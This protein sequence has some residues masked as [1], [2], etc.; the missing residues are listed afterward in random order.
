MNKSSEPR[1]SQPRRSAPSSS[2]ASAVSGLG[3][4]AAAW[5]ALVAVQT[6]ASERIGDVLNADA[7]LRDPGCDP[8]DATLA[9]ELALGAIRF[10]VL[11]DRLCD[12]F[13]RR[14]R[15][16][17]EVR[18]ALRLAAHQLFACDSVPPHAVGQ[19]TGALLRRAQCP[20]LVAVA[21]AVVRRLSELRLDERQGDGP[22]G[23]IDPRAHPEDEA[24]R[25]G[26]P[27]ALIRDLSSALDADGKRAERLAAMTKVPP[28]CTRHRPGARV[29]V[30][31]SVIKQEGDWWWWDDPQEAIHGHVADGRLVVQDRSQGRLLELVEPRPLDRVFDTCAAPGG[32]ALLFYDAGC[33]VVA[34]D[35]PGPRLDRMRTQMPAD[36]KIIAH[37][38]RDPSLDQQ[39]DIVLV[40]APCSNSGVLARRP[41]AMLR[42]DAKHLKSLEQLQHHLLRASADLVAPGGKLVYST[43]SLAPQENQAIA[44]RLPGWRIWRQHTIWPDGWQAGSYAAVLVRSE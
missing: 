20:H 44:H 3:A 39:Y 1:R 10:A 42:Y 37:D 43:C 9:R 4:R 27:T 8:R 25:Y 17:P 14:G 38:G 12:G 18:H 40:D 22:L 35:V 33:T 19:T 23:R 15:Q 24:A 7:S 5:D 13:L 32:K 28:L 21:N 16:P 41:E 2:A 26:L 30:G 29:P 36:M 6:G 34:A 31:K 11:Y